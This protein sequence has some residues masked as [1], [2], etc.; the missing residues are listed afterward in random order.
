MLVQLSECKSSE[1]LRSLMLTTRF[2][3]QL[4]TRKER[5]QRFQNPAMAIG[6]VRASM[7]D[8]TMPTE[9]T[10]MALIGIT[11]AANLFH[12]Q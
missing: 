10:A 4:T 1:A 5:A 9:A 6:G 12:S 8:A 7:S 3:T 11:R 2:V